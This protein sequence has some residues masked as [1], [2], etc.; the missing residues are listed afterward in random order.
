MAVSDIVAVSISVQD[1]SP[2]AASFDTTVVMSKAPFV[3][4]RLYNLT[5]AGLSAMTT[6]GFASYDRAYQ[7]ASR[8]AGQTGGAG[9]IYVSARTSSALSTVRLTV[10]VSKTAVGETIGFTYSYQGVSAAISHT[11]VTNTVDAILD[12]FE[13]DMVASAVETAGAATVPDGGVATYLEITGDVVGDAVHVDL[14][15]ESALEL[16]VVT[17]ASATTLTDQLAAMKA[18]L[19]DGVFG[20]LIDT[21]SEVEI[22]EAAAFALANNMVFLG[23]CPNADI[24]DSGSTTDIASDLQTA[25]NTSANVGF[26]RNMSSDWCAGLMGLQLGQTPGSSTWAFKTI[27]GAAADKLS[28][29]DLAVARGKN[30][31]TYVTQRG[32]NHTYDGFTA[33]GRFFDITHGVAFL[34][35]DIETR[36]FQ[37]LLNAQKIPFNEAGRALIEGELRGALNASSASGLIEPDFEIFIPEIA[38]ISAVDKAARSFTGV[39]F[40]ATLTGAVHSVTVVGTLRL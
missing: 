8:M 12:A 5:P 32:V 14:G 39:T 30:A 3:G 9:S 22:N 27:A 24:L 16:T 38:D 23:Q 31:L 13:A 21:Q 1:S 6:D 28:D 25:G 17:P 40:S 2:K 20:L 10:D 34:R 18:R 36:M 4:D 29:S 33:G 37:L 15:D 35:S 19:G 26:S 7:M 11:I